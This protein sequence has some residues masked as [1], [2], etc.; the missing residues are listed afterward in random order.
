MFPAD[1]SLT[2][3]V[4]VA[5]RRVIRS[6]E[7]HSR[8]LM[9]THGLTGPQATLLRALRGGPLTAGDLAQR[10]NLSQGTV[11][12]ILNRLE[13]RE[14]LVR[15]RDTTDR[16]RVIVALTDPARDLLENAPPLLQERFSQRFS[17]LPD[18]EQSQLLAA[19]QRIAHM[20][21]ADELDAL[22][23]ILTTAP[24]IEEVEVSTKSASVS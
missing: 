15:H 21:D 16:R 12:D 1:S 22:A 23:P 6:I 7:L 9:V 4:I 3:Q 8:A 13:Q 20:M 14:L 17:Q 18:W 24:S 2:D 11:T 10:V 19:L 5:L